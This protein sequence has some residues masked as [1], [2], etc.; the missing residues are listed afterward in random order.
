MHDATLQ[1]IVS[2]FDEGFLAV[3]DHIG[4]HWPQHETRGDLHEAN[5]AFQVGNA[6]RAAGCLVYLETPHAG[7]TGCRCD[8][9]VID[10]RARWALAAEFKNVTSQAKDIDF[11]D[12]ARRLQ[13][14]RLLATT[15]AVARHDL[16][17]Y[18]ALA[19]GTWTASHYAWWMG[20]ALRDE[21][22]AGSRRPAEW[23]AVRDFLAAGATV[24]A[25]DI[26]V[27]APH[28]GLV[29][30]ALARGGSFWAPAAAAA[31]EHRGG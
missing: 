9:L 31:A 26:R 22:P 15:G 29:A 20:G 4:A 14:L 7:G 18:V 2:R 17:C 25:T 28:W 1:E 24:H 30:T 8:L 21:A 13:A 10:P 6:F 11:A 5:L 23:A 27:R 3:R 19:F 12:D 16:R